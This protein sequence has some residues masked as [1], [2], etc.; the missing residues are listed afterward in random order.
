MKIKTNRGSVLLDD[1]DYASLGHKIFVDTHGYACIG[2]WDKELKKSR[3]ERLHRV[4]M[5]CPKGLYVDHISGDKLDNRRSNLRICTNQ[6]NG[7]NRTRL[8]K[9]NKSGERGI[10]WDKVNSCWSVQIKFNYKAKRIGR[11]KD[12]VEAIKA[13]DDELEKVMNLVVK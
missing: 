10:Y 12:L 4:V 3:P 1:E 13:R 9:N 5:K 2:Y 11:F 6:V 7:L 8:N